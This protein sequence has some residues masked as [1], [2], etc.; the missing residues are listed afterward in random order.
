MKSETIT[1]INDDA[2]RIRFIDVAKGV[3]II[4]VILMHTLQHDF[5]DSKLYIFLLAFTMPLFFICSGFISPLSKKTKIENK[6]KGLLIPTVFFIFLN[7]I[8]FIVCG[9]FEKN[10][11]TLFKFGGFWFLIAL[12]CCYL[13]N[14]LLDYIFERKKPVYRIATQI[15]ISIVLISAGFYVST[16][17]NSFDAYYLNF[18]VAYPFLTIGQLVRLIFEKM[19]PEF[20]KKIHVRIISGFISLGLLVVGFLFSGY[21]IPVQMFKNEYG[22]PLLFIAFSLCGSLGILG[23]CLCIWKM[24]PLEWVGKK[25]LIIMITHFPINALSYLLLSKMLSNTY[26]IF[27]LNFV[28]VV[29]AEIVV[30]FL[31]FRFAPVIFGKMEQRTNNVENN[32]DFN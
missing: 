21:D 13:V 31:L 14:Y 22:N 9:L 24:L 5:N 27:A 11:Y 15:I 18:F 17:S 28:I 32:D 29:G 16:K 25:S 10:Y 3:G 23:L 6:V 20:W 7:V 4:L 8:I 12:F 19:N 26:V 30:S 2:N 1:K